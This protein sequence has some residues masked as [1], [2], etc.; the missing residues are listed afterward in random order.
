LSTI[1][2]TGLPALLKEHNKNFKEFGPYLNLVHGPIQYNLTQLPDN[3][4]PYVVDILKSISQ[5]DVDG[6]MYEHHIPG[7][8]NFI[9]NGTANPL[10]W[11]KFKQHIKTHD[12]Y[13]EQNFA[14]VYPEYAKAIN[15]E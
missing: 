8:I 1:N 6:Y 12:E 5:E 10:N 2:I 13:R 7:I 4:K 9:N 14:M 3:I 15:Y 11:E